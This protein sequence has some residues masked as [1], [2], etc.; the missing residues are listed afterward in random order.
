MA[1]MRLVPTSGER[2]LRVAAT[3]FAAIAIVIGAVASAPGAGAIGAT[4]FHMSRGSGPP[5]THVGVSGSGCAPGLLLPS[6]F[7]TVA[8]AT[9]PPTSV[10]LP[11]QANGS[12]SGSFTVPANAAAAPAAVSAVCLSSGLPSL[13]TIYTPKT[14][15][16]TG[17][18]VP[19]SLALPSPTLPGTPAIT[20]PSDPGAPHPGTS[21]PVAAPNDRVEHGPPG[22]TVGTAGSADSKAGGEAPGWATIGTAAWAERHFNSGPGARAAEL[23]SPALLASRGGDGAGLGW[24]LWVLALIL[25]IAGGGFYLWMRHARR[26]DVADLEADSA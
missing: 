24:L 23:S 15:T 3:A 17:N 20:T 8:A 5:G 16:V 22:G 19:T 18:L 25:P 10:D 21:S 14:F 11:V 6:N 2:A 13:L 1:E 9:V 12:W 26:P 7:V 4:S